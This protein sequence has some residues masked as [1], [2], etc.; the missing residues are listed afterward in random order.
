M[1][2]G[3]RTEALVLGL[4]LIALG[5]LWTLGNLGYLDAL[6]VLRVW[7]PLSLVVWGAAELVAFLGGR[8]SRR[9]SE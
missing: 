5:V 1:A 8:A 4:L 6:S 3:Y 9:S 7:W 2:A